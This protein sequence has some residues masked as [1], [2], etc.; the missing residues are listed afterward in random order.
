MIP[1]RLGF[2]VSDEREKKLDNPIGV[3]NNKVVLWHSGIY[4]C[5]YPAEPCRDGL[6]DEVDVAFRTYL[7]FDGYFHNTWSCCVHPLK[8]CICR[9]PY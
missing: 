7:A 1:G 9:C 3:D 4:R 5:S 2:I 6:V 8:N